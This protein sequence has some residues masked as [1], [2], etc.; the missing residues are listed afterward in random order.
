MSLVNINFTQNTLSGMRI[1]VQWMKKI[2]KG[3]NII[4]N[5]SL[6]DYFN[7]CVQVLFVD[8]GQNGIQGCYW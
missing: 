1:L 3:R 6:N 8:L 4:W 5:H 2:W 7:H